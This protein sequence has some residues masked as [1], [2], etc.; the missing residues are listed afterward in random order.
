MKLYKFITINEGNAS[1]LFN[2]N[3]LFVEEY[4]RTQKLL[5]ALAKAGW[6][7]VSMNPV[8]TPNSL[9]TGSFSF[10][11]GGFK[12]LFEKEAKDESE[13]DFDQIL[14]KVFRD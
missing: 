6:T 12:Y 13:N 14:Y 3:F 10:Y 1:Q 11:R 4:P 9:K 7:I 2:G 8:Y 5:E